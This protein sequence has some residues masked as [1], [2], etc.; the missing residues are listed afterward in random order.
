MPRDA[1]A[2]VDG[3]VPTVMLMAGNAIDRLRDLPDKSVHCIC[4]SPPYYCLRSYL[5]KDDPL[6]AFEIG[7]ERTP[8]DYIAKLVAVFAECRRVLRDDGTCWIVIADSY[9]RNPARG[10]KFEKKSDNTYIYN[11]QQVVEQ[12]V[13]TSIPPGLK[14]GDLIGIPETLFLALRDDGWWVRSRVSWTK[15]SVMPESIKSRPSSAH[16]TVLMLT[17]GM[18]YFYDIHA[19]AEPSTSDH[20]SGNGFKRDARVSYQETDGSPRGQDE[21]WTDVGGTRQL[22]NVWM[23]N[24]EPSREIH[25]AM[26]P[27]RLASRCIQASTSKFGCCPLCGAPYRRI[28]EKTTPDAAHQAACGA[29]LS[30]GYAGTSVKDYATANAQ[31]ASATKAR[32]LVG[33]KVKR[34]V[35]WERTCR[36]PETALPPTPALVLDPFSGAGSTLLSA[37][38]LGRDAV[39]IDLHPDYHTSIAAKR[40]A[41]PKVKCLDTHGERL[42]YRRCET[43]FDAA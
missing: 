41:D 19:V 38:R 23:I 43:A 35:G 27:T 29:D 24:P 8:T 39:G 21:Q 4:T 25:F 14:E 2:I 20:P 5:D 1:P 7:Q 6:K 15:N 16:E 26:F 13:R 36:C 33:M 28:V 32:I 10:I 18:D 9:A 37:V 12:Y 22:R 11:R 34:T 30:G 17:K 31:D 40:L 42:P 3:V